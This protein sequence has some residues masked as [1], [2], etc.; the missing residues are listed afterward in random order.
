MTCLQ[1]L[2]FVVCSSLESQLHKAG[3]FVLFADT[4]EAP[5]GVPA[6]NKPQINISQMNEK[7]EIYS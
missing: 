4:A 7:H 5:R 1:C 3:I 2:L 6:H